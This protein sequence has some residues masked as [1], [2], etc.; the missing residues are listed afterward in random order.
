MVGD[1]PDA[2][3]DEAEVALTGE[4]DRN[5]VARRGDVLFREAGPWSGTVHSLLRHL[6]GVGFAGAPRVVGTGFDGRG[7]EMLSYVAGEVIN[8]RPWADDAMPVLGRL[9]RELHDATASF[10]PPEGA[11]WRRWFAHDLGGPRRVIGHGDTSPW[12]VVSRGG[13]PVALV[14]WEFAG[15]IDPMVELAHACR[16]NARLFDDVIAAKEGLAPPD[17]RAR[18]VRLLLDGYGLSRAGRAGFVD[19]MVE[20]AVCNAADEVNEASAA[21]ESRE[22]VR[23]WAITW[24]TRSAAWMLRHRAALERAL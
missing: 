3:D 6:E 2:S 15:P 19:R 11:V 16:L 4:G 18:Q 20:C 17:D 12:N 24:Q 10:V 21:W 13:V 14:D 23:L 22:S 9:L 5:A 7:R 1:A 8:P